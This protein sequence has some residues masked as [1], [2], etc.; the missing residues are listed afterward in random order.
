VKV[1][2]FFGP[3]HLQPLPPPQE[4]TPDTHFVWR[5]KRPQGHSVAGRFTSKKNLNDPIGNRTRH[6]L[7]CSDCFTEQI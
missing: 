7:D 6:L 5:L 3:N 2:M 1:A 4:D